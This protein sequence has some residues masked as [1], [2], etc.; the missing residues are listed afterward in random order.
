MLVQPPLTDV[1]GF[2]MIIRPRLQQL[3][4]DDRSL[5]FLKL[6][7]TMSKFESSQ[8]KKAAKNRSNQVQETSSETP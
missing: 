7:K 1:E 4:P 6:L 8:S 2:F 5:A 3:T